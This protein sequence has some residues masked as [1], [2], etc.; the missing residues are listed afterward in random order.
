MVRERRTALATGHKMMK[1]D[2]L[3]SQPF[4]MLR[5]GFNKCSYGEACADTLIETF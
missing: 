1:N 3:T 5:C 2:R 4:G